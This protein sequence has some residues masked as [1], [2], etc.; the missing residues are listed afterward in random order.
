MQTWIDLD[1]AQSPFLMLRLPEP[2]GEDPAPIIEAFAVALVA[3]GY[4]N[5]EP[6]KS[7]PEGLMLLGRAMIEAIRTAF[8]MRL[9]MAPPKGAGSADG[10]EGFGDWALIMAALVGQ[11]GL[12]WNEALR[13]PVAQGLGLLHAFKRNEGWTVTGAN[14]RQRQLEAGHDGEVAGG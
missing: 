4:E 11:V 14:Y 5:P 6:G 7:D 9:R 10:D 2:A 1:E 12:S 8:A 3:F 13:M